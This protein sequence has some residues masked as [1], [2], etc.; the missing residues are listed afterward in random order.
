MRIPFEWLGEYVDLKGVN[1]KELSDALN[2]TGTENEVIS[3]MKDFPGIVV[4]EILE[5]TKHPN[6]DKLQIT[7]TQVGKNDIRQIVCGANNIEV[8]QKVPV[9]LPGAVIGEFEIKEAELRGIKSQGMLCSEAELG[10]SDDHSGI[11]ILNPDSRIG[12]DLGKALSTGGVVL[13]AE[14]TPNRSDCFS[15]LGIAREAAASINKKLKRLPFENIT[16][17]S[18]KKVAVEV[19]E[20]ELCPRYIAKVIENI[21]VAESPEWLQK[22]LS[23]SGVRPINNIVDATNY[24]MLELG[25]P[26][27][28]FDE[29]NISGK[30][31][32]R[33]AK[34][35]ESVETLDGVKRKLTVK[36]LVIADNKK[37][38]AVAG[39]MGG[40]NSEVTEK[41]KNIVLE[42]AV[43]DGTSVR[44]T[45]QR[46]GIRTEASGRF[47]KSIP[48]SLPELAIERA[49]QLIIEIAG[50]K[51]GKK[52][53]V[54]SK[55]IWV[56]HAG[57]RV[58]KLQQ[59]LGVNISSEEAISILK[60]LGFE[61]EKF[62]FKKEARKHI[63]K[64]YVLGA[65]FKSHG[66]MA[67]DCSYF[68]DYIYSLIGKFIGF[69][70]LA[71]Y[72]LG[73][74]VNKEDLQP[75]D[76]LFVNGVIDKSVT[77]HYFIPDGNGGYKKVLLEKSKRVGH[78][79][80]YIGNGRIVHA[81]HFNYDF[82][83]NNWVKGKKAEVVEEDL[84]VFT[85]N[86][87][88]LGARRYVEDSNDWI[89]I[90]V[91]WWR[92]DVKIEEDILEEVG[93]IYGLEKIPS[94]LPEGKLPAYEENKA[95]ELAG[96]IRETLTGV[97]FSEVINYSFVSAEELCKVAVTSNALKVFNPISPQTEYLRT[98]LVPSL[99]KNAFLNQGNFEKFNI[100]E[101]G[102]TFKKLKDGAQE[103][104][105]LG[106]VSF[107]P[108][109]RTGAAYYEIKG[110]L[111]VLFAKHRLS[112]DF[113]KAQVPYL[114]KEQTA[115][116]LVNN[117]E[118]GYI[119]VT[120]EKTTADFDLKKPVGIAEINLE[121]LLGLINKEI[122]Y[123][124]VSR[125]PIAVRDIS[126]IIK[127]DIEAKII[128]EK[129]NLEGILTKA[130]IRDI[131]QGTGLAQDEKSVT[132]RLYFGS[133]EKTLS[134][135]EISEKVDKVLKDLSKLGSRL[136][137]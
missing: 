127:N 116:I 126:L 136:R 105:T 94:L 92:L 17:T 110:A 130:E 23:Q 25:Q 31:I 89:A 57:L 3:D 133:Q 123:K 134:E 135:A 42:A 87:E 77:E 32:V 131:Y 109:K 63:G 65:S 27:H 15:I 43:F 39:V 36:D 120:N 97:G 28:A 108:G 103:E 64:P 95:V 59:F 46:I 18:K 49:A 11:M 96:S 37:V 104:N 93:R 41:T 8:G 16:E 33:K 62:D 47:E 29:S 34:A 99:L 129:I 21:K 76:V 106:L 19:K 52:E 66:N 54:L 24:V 80:M 137:S 40:T 67:F 4:G 78:N 68:T 114:E 44:K 22:R 26:L 81:K 102:A 14:I 61:A 98:T 101:I 58:S 82:S 121:L 128:L 132:I 112:A 118:I 122:N 48:L 56:Q 50:G 73:R 9:A 20:K 69:T 107:S 90:D 2:L 111:E 38:I 86:P 84:E 79:A 88:Y 60:S 35:D 74:E 125:F 51:A 71:Q 7:K 55:W 45:A 13:E 72:E 5:I 70:S 6:A 119:G 12:E 113:V 75:G 83:K 91:P 53:D 1:P 10:I 124:P 117:K 115:K 30:I 100:F 85:N